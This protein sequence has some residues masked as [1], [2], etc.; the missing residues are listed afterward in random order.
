IGS[1]GCHRRAPSAA[2]PSSARGM[3][4]ARLARSG[5]R[6]GWAQ[7]HPRPALDRRWPGSPAHLP[8]LPHLARGSLLWVQA[9]LSAL[10]SL[11]ALTSA[12][13]QARL[14]ALVQPL[15]T[16]VQPAAPV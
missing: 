7:A 1:A 3:P 5:R 4:P 10:T 12:F 8:H 6:G 14:S 9:V 15:V 16:P 11:W 2:A 13:V